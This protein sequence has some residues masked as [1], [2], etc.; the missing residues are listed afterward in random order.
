MKD[1]CRHLDISDSC[2][3]DRSEIWN[4][5]SLLRRDATPLGRMLSSVP[6]ESEIIGPMPGRL[7]LAYDHFMSAPIEKPAISAVTRE[8]LLEVLGP[9]INAL[10]A[11][12]GLSPSEWQV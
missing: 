8:R 3:S 9:D 5:S 6:L 10:R 1:L 7:Q 11:L 4:R 2:M 12:T